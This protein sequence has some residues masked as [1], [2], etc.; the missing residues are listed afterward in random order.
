MITTAGTTICAELLP[1]FPNNDLC[2]LQT[3]DLV[4]T[5]PCVRLVFVLLPC[6]T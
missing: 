5:E 4:A 3:V 6:V 2:L 1:S